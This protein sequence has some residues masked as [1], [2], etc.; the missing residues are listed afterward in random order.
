VGA[1]RKS[2]KFQKKDSRK[3]ARRMRSSAVAPAYGHSWRV[4]TSLLKNYGG[5]FLMA[6][7]FILGKTFFNVFSHGA[8]RHPVWASEEFCFFGLGVVIWTLWFFGS[9]WAL[10]EPRPL[11]VYVFGHELTHAIW[12]W[13]M[14]G[15]V[16]DFKARAEG[17]Y[18]ITDTHN[19]WIALAPYFYP[20]YSIAAIV[21][22]G[23]IS[24]FYDL[25]EP[26]ISFLWVSPLQ[27]LFLV[28][29]I[30]WAFHLTFTCWMIPKGQS[31]LMAHGVFFSLMVIIIMNLAVLCAFLVVASHDLTWAVFGR[32]L[33]ENTEDFST[34]AWNLLEWLARAVKSL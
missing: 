7:A 13:L 4:P 15:R 25:N 33:L 22:Y 31:D 34:V 19:F 5:L 30:T 20:V 6:P 24:L 11:G 8:V 12:V 10:G 3:T 9:I 28:L 32:K 16:F 21:F 14:R 29:G 23:A 1:A 27:W 18:I 17:G 26:H 2:I